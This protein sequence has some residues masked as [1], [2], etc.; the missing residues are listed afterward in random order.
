MATNILT[1]L[2][3]HYVAGITIAGVDYATYRVANPKE[4]RL[5]EKRQC[6]KSI[7]YL[8]DANASPVQ[9]AEVTDL[10]DKLK[11]AEG[12][13]PKTMVP[14]EAIPP[15]D[16]R[17][18]AINVELVKDYF[19]KSG[20]VKTDIPFVLKVKNFFH[21]LIYTE[22][23]NDLG[24]AGRIGFAIGAEVLYD[25]LGGF[26]HYSTQGYSPIAAFG[27]N[28]L[29]IPFFWAGLVTGKGAKKVVNAVSIHGEERKLDKAID[30]SIK[31]TSIVDI[32]LNYEPPKEV[33]KELESNGIKSQTAELTSK[34]RDMAAEFAHNVKEGLK[35]GVDYLPKKLEEFQ[36]ARKEAEEAERKA[37]KSR[38]DEL[39][40]GH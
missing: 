40:K 22:R 28:A 23:I 19:L 5:E 3:W 11:E 2:A 37:R 16:S 17:Q 15:K 21:D 14:V 38:F 35:K 4:K 33:Q 31:N 13:A 32:V 36:K 27:L 12:E 30:K 24:K 10:S 34:G 1:D 18:Y 7:A 6:F 9:T 25:T 39:T 8:L 20:M 26:N 29:Q